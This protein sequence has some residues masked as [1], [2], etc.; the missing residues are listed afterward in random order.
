VSH[1][2]FLRDIDERNLVKLRAG[3]MLDRLELAAFVDNVLDDAPAMGRARLGNRGAAFT[4]VSARPRSYG[5]S[6]S[7]R[8]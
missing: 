8:F 1:D 6:L 5:M 4:N 2:P 7:Y 3:V